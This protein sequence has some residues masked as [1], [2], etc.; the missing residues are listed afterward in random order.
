MKKLEST[1]TVKTAVNAGVEKVWQTWTTPA[2]IMLW[3]NPSENWHNTLVE[4]ELH[5]GGNFLFEMR[6]KD[7]SEGFDYVGKYDKILTNELIELTTRDGRKAINNFIAEGDK[8]IV[9]ETFTIDESV[10]VE[11]QKEFCQ[12]ILDSFK[13][14]VEDKVQ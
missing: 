14:Y 6:A 10:S 2:D 9:T 12:N 4:V 7:G 11:L 5:N 3:N 13:R 1:V 8:T